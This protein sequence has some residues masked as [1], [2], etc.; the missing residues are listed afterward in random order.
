MSNDALSRMDHRQDAREDMQYLVQPRGPGKSWVFRMVTPSELVGV[1]NPWDGRPLGKEIKRGLG[2][3]R[4]TEARK[5]RDIAL[6]DIRRLAD[7]FTDGSAFSLASAVEWREAIRE[8]RKLAAA[9]GDPAYVAEEFV[10]QDKLEAAEKR[11]LPREQ[12]KRFARVATGR[13]FPLELAHREYVAARSEGN[14][15]GYKTLKKTSVISL[16]SAVKHLR[17][18][19]GDEAGTACLEDVSPEVAQVFRDAYLPTVK[20]PR[21]PNGLSPQTITKNVNMLK[22]VWVWAD[23]QGH[24]A[25]GYANP[26]LFKR[27]IARTSGRQDQGRQDYQP[28]ET[29]K[30]L[31]ATSRGTRQGDLVRL[32]IAT[33]CRVN[34]IATIASK[35]VKPDASGFYL[36][37]GKTKNALRYVPVVEEA[38]AVLKARMAV[39]GSTGRLF[40]EWPIRPASDKAASVSQWFTR[41]RRKTLGKETDGRLA[42]HST[43]H[44]WKTVA[45]RAGV[46]EAAVNELGGWEGPKTSS[47]VYDHG[48]LEA[49]L[50]AAQA[51]VWAE[52]KR[53]GYLEGF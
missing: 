7:G 18:Y 31:A 49:Q 33:G 29:S 52:L 2:T 5:L 4:L 9:Q 44:T 42:L 28:G 26:W 45:R 12:L 19:L 53:A 36:H 24:L 22:Q 30:L 10:M 50:E 15:Y 38:R 32:A 34:E 13:G 39:H 51:Q 3:R 21:S 17:A 16:E 40:P 1:P 37:D 11:G 41:F 47:S 46:N 48:L 35:N 23:E 6:G 20:G 8:A 25:N 27:G 14:A 43:R